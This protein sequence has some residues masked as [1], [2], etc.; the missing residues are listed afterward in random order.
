MTYPPGSDV[1]T[2]QGP[3]GNSTVVDTTVYLTVTWASAIPAD[4]TAAADP[5]SPEMTRRVRRDHHED[6]TWLTIMEVWLA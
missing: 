3:H 6:P 4:P 5:P 1:V 2:S